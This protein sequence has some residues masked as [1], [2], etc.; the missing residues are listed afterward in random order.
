VTPARGIVVLKPIETAETL[1]Q[2]RIILTP[3]TREA[4][5]THQME[6]VSVGKLPYCED[7]ECDRR[8]VVEHPGFPIDNHWLK[9]APRNHPCDAKP[10][11]WV[12]VRHR[13]LTETHQD[14]LYCCHQDDVLAVLQ[15]PV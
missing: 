7:V 13:S 15:A 3:S 5:T 14:G 11:D 1:G 8:H 12:L 2:G 6:V 4:L 9:T 10:G